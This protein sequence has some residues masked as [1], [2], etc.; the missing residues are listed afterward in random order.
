MNDQAVVREIE[1]EQLLLKQCVGELLK[2]KLL[3]CKKI[4]NLRRRELR[5]LKAKSALTALVLFLALYLFGILTP[6]AQ[7]QEAKI[8]D[9]PTLSATG[10]T[11]TFNVWKYRDSG[12]HNWVSANQVVSVALGTGTN[13]ACTWQL[14]A[15]D[16]GTNWYSVLTSQTCTA[17]SYLAVQQIPLRNLRVHVTAYTGTASLT[18]HWTGS[19]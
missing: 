16:D 18:F 12:G 15:S 13:S 7:A 8:Y 6:A 9:W 14:E 19:E 1:K 3:I 17:N 2:Q 10:Y 11:T 4:V 5:L